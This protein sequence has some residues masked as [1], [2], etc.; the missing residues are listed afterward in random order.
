MQFFTAT[1]VQN[2][3]IFLT[4]LLQEKLALVMSFLVVFRQVRF[5][6]KKVRVGRGLGWSAGRV[7]VRNVRVRARFLKLLR[8]ECGHKISTGAGL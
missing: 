3:C 1:F 6:T 8:G 5:E 4:I 7:Q 2:K